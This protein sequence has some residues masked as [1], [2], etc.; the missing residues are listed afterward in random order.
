VLQN[1][2]G[3]VSIHGPMARSL[4][5]GSYDETG[6]T[7]LWRLLNGQMP[8]YK[9]PT[10]PFNRTGKAKGT[11]I[12]GN[13][14]LLFALIGSPYDFEPEGKILFIEDVGEYLY[15][16]DRM[17]R[18]L[19]LSGKLKGLAGLV[20]GQMSDMQ[21][22][23]TPFGLSVSQIIADVVKEYDFPVLFDFPA[24]HSKQNEPLLFGAKVKLSVSADESTLSFL[25]PE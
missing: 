1:V 7:N 6:M 11:L 4:K 15:H 20:V 2:L 22:N 24:G 13:L 8:V 12:G 10:H 9:L 16:L 25:K 14:S 19:K 23:E 5:E 17:M 21:D 3:V 18:A